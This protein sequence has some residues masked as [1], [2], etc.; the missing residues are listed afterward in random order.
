[1]NKEEVKAL[2]EIF[3]TFNEKLSEIEK[4]INSADLNWFTNL[5]VQEWY[6]ELQDLMVGEKRI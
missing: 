4:H 3:K 1:M 6:T 5:A 2:G